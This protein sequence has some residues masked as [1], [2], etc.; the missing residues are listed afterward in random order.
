MFDNIFPCWFSRCYRTVFKDLILLLTA[1]LSGV[2]ISLLSLH[3]LLSRWLVATKKICH[4]HA[5]VIL[6]WFGFESCLGNERFSANPIGLLPDHTHWPPTRTSHSIRDYRRQKQIDKSSIITIFP[7]FLFRSCL[8]ESSIRAEPTRIFT[9]NLKG[10]F[11]FF[12]KTYNH[13]YLD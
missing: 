9:K 2:F 13:V 3:L 6:F 11:R 12:R 1:L 10:T 8:L 5:A 4:L 7:L